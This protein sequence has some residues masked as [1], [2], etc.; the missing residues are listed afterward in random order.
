MNMITAKC[1][2]CGGTATGLTY[3]EA[4]AKINHGVGLG[5]GIKCGAS[6]NKVHEVKPPVPKEPPVKPK[7]P[8]PKQV[9]PPKITLDE[10]VAGTNAET[11]KP[12]KSKPTKQ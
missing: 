10:P 4:S 7:A 5:K 3:E 1:D 11:V 9:T 12:T 8:K 6:Y 2:R